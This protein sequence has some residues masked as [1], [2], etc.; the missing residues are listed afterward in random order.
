MK[1]Y[2][3]GIYY[4]LDT[5]SHTATVVAPFPHEQYFNDYFKDYFKM[6]CYYIRQNEKCA[7]YKTKGAIKS[8]KQ[9]TPITKVCCFFNA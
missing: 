7:F 9:Q 6:Y 3:D 5:S 4:D 8:Q 2:I 1:E